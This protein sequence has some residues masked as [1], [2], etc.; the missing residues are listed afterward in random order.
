MTSSM[1]GFCR[2]RK[3][4]IICRRIMVNETENETIFRRLAQPR[5]DCG[6]DAGDESDGTGV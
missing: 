4:M 1:I 6:T 5:D 2:L 3:G